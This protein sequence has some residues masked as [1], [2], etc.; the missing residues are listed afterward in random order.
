M[1]AAKV[2]DIISRLPGCAGQAADSVS[3]AYTDKVK[4]EDAHK[5]LKIPKNRISSMTC[6]HADIWIREII[7]LDEGLRLG[8][9][10]ALDLWDLIVAVLGNMYQSNQL[11]GDLCT[12]Q[13]EV[14]AVLHT[15]QRLERKKSHGMINDLDNVDLF[16][17]M[18]NL[19]VRKLCCMCHKMIFKGRS[20]DN[21]TCFQDP[22]SCS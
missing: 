16:P 11:R 1:T 9:I 22:Q 13:R 12:N 5:L 6:G 3:Y 17:Q 10:T 14:R 15:L 4:M 7:S 20:P 19:L 2:M 21:E 18:S 8:G